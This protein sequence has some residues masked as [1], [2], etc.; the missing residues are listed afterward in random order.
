MDVSILSP[1][2]SFTSTRV[3]FSGILILLTSVPK[4][5]NCF[6]PK[7]NVPQSSDADPDVTFAVGSSDELVG[8]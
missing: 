5:K 8:G 2:N 3:V 1:R 7:L 4:L 6:P